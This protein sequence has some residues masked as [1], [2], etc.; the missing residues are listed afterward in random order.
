[1]RS[2]IF[3]ALFL[4]MLPAALRYAHVAAML[5][6]WIATVS[7]TH[8]ILGFAQE[9]PFNK[10][11]VVVALIALVVDRQ[12]RP[13]LKFDVHSVLLLAFL[14]VAM[15]SY[16]VAL[17]RTPRVDDL[18]DRM[19]KVVLLVLFVMAT[20]RTRLQIH[21]VLIAACMGMGIHGA[22]EAA[23][24]VASGGNHV[25]L[26]PVTIGDNNH[27]GLAIMMVIAPLAYL[28]RYS[29]ALIIKFA[30]AVAA[31]CNV[32]GV[33]ASNS[34]GALIGL[35]AV[36]GAAFFRSQN[37]LAM[38]LVIAVMAVVGASIAPDRWYDRMSSIKEAEEDT[39]FLSRIGSWKMNLLVALDRPLTGGGF[40]AMEDPTVF[41]LYVPQFQSVNVL[42]NSQVPKRAYAAHSIYFQVLGDTGFVGLVLFVVL[43]LCAFRNITV[44]RRLAGDREDLKWAKDLALALEFSLVAYAVSGAGLSMAYFEFYYVLIT[45]AAIVRHNVAAEVGAEATKTVAR[46]T[47]HPGIQ[48]GPSVAR[49]Q[50]ASRRFGL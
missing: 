24:F 20:V 46:R 19:V 35:V 6:V 23:K 15:I 32:V 9:V 17:S 37:K 47:V 42:I 10:V 41:S 26:A 40:S 13:K 49:P 2:F 18:A 16:M 43:L 1:M 36:G 31:L 33:I 45:L 25:L 21:S 12:Y 3:S 28:Y 22:I 11:V 48:V 27:F 34:R 38:A 5:W 8:Y 44:A 39:S 29:Q 4:A 7:T 30:F 50:G 14:A